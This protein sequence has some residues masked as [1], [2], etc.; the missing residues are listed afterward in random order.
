MFAKNGN[1][2]YGFKTDFVLTKRRFFSQIILFSKSKFTLIYI[3]INFIDFYK[4]KHNIWGGGITL[5]T[6]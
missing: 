4:F 2:K 6:L 3:R 1:V 5:T